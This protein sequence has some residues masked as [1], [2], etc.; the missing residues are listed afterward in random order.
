M[1]QM[2][3]ALPAAEFNARATEKGWGAICDPTL[4]FY[5][6]ELSGILRVWREAAGA[7]S[8]PLRSS[9]TPR[10]LKDYLPH[11]AFYERVA[12]E[13]GA[14][15]YR[16]RL[17]GSAYQAVMG[18]HTGKFL[19]EFLPPEHL[20]LWSSVLDTIL[21]HGAPLRFLTRSEITGR[22]YLV[23]E[24]CSAP[25]V[26]RSG[27]PNLVLAVGYYGADRRWEDVVA[28]VPR[29]AEPA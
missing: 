25:V 4:A 20:D 21:K 23:G 13:A 8:V 1:N 7:H 9:L 24:Y 27:E 11:I 28:S 3:P 26:D 16:I 18:E 22:N 10:L 6:P 5:R 29:P 15:R 17:L 12:N 14:W 2:S 19:D